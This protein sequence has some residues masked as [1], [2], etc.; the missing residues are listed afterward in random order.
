MIYLQK[1]RKTKKRI[2]IIK[3]LKETTVKAI[4]F[5]VHLQEKKT[6]KKENP[7]GDST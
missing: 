2:K 6:K 7:N 1:K 5:V 4:Q 3:Y